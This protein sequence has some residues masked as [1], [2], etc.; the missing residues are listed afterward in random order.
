MRGRVLLLVFFLAI[1]VVLIRY[2]QIQIIEG[3]EHRAY[4]DSLRT[5]MV[6]LNPKRGRILSADGAVLAWSEE[7]LTARISGRKL[8]GREPLDSILGKERAGELLLGKTITVNSVEASELERFGVEI[9][10][11]IVRRYSGLA[12]HVV[13]YV[14]VDGEG[15]SG[16][17]RR[18]NDVLKG[19]AGSMLLM[20]DP[21]GRIKGKVLESPPTSGED[22]VLTIISG[23]QS[24]AEEL[25]REV[26]KPGAIIVM[27][28]RDGSILAMASYP[29]FD[30]NT[31]S[32]EIEPRDWWRLSRD[33]KGP[34]INRSISALYP[35]GSAIKPFVALSYMLKVGKREETVDC[36]GKFY[37]RNRSG[38]VVAT[39]WDWLKTGHGLTDLVKAIRVSCNVYFYTIGLET[40]IDFMRKIAYSVDLDGTTG[41]DLPGEVSGLFPSRGWKEKEYGEIWYPGDTILVSIGQGYVRLTP[42]E[43][44]EFYTLIA[45]EG[46][47]YVPH[48]L[49]RVG[50]E[51]IE[52][53]I[54]LSFDAP[55]WIWRKLKRALIEVTS[56]PG[57][58]EN[59]GTAYIAF[60]GFD[61]DVAGKTGTAEVPGGTHSWFIG[62]APAHDPEIAVVVVV[63]R[64]GSGG[65][66][67]APMAREIFQE[68]FHPSP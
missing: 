14:N 18:E 36:T 61:I 45:N 57:N 1:P 53:K 41:V 10:K 58:V 52:P 12:P 54:R 46:V 60:R 26:G 25:L 23:I 59:R 39:Y 40:G 56:H 16:I 22:L 48:V 62:F 11:R 15:V 51:E 47:E 30:P 5:Y 7:I 65:E 35:P 42:I 13:G 37:Y 6:P 38:E 29:S 3:D 20:V 34:F 17:E 67:A 2:F 68:Y 50:D 24:K 55:K 64:G 63:E 28:V 32:G 49:K 44:L 66:V 19:K 21:K 4:M 9:S 27:N 43:L 8:P 33:P 31:V